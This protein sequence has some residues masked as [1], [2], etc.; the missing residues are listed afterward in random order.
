MDS[1]I[2]F[3]VIGVRFG[4]GVEAHQSRSA[5]LGLLGVTRGLTEQVLQVEEHAIAGVLIFGSDYVVLFHLSF[6]TL[7]FLLANSPA[8]GLP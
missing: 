1:T 3:C 6:E 4:D 8:T 7:T 5:T 2:G